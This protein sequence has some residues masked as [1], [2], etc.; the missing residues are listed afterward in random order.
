M[1][2]TKR[3]AEHVI[4]YMNSFSKT[5]FVAVRFGNVLGSHG[6]VIPLFRKQIEEG[7]PV[8]VTHKDITR[9][10]MTIPE[11]SRLV[12]QAGNLAHKGEIFILDMGEQ[13]R[14]DDMARTLIRLSGYEPDID[15]QIVYT[16]LRPG[17]KLYEELFLDEEKTEKTEAGGIMVGHAQ[18]PAPE[19]IY[20]NL[21]WLK[22]QVDAGADIR[23]CLQ[24]I[25]PTYQPLTNDAIRSDDS[26]DEPE[27]VDMK[28][29][30]PIAA[31]GYAC[32]QQ[33]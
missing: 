7:G 24:K 15:I 23:A 13:I 32:R 1:G 4:Q 9:F 30:T 25:L 19:V 8:T 14:I 27:T 18:H 20:D 17:E 21:V 12:L 33:S 28:E 26:A 6:S 31:G 16:G 29:P 5:Q 11:A 2:A 10:F 3:M 22:E